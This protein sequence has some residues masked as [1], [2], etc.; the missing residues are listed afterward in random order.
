[1]NYIWW[2]M[3]SVK[4]S[5][6]MSEPIHHKCDTGEFPSKQPGKYDSELKGWQ[7]MVVNDYS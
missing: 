4:Y 3:P 2:S 5:W 1:M 6:I 7:L